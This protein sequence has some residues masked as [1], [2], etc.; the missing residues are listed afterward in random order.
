MLTF[1]ELDLIPVVP[2][3]GSV[4]ASGDLAPLSHLFL[5]LLG[6]GEFWQSKSGYGDIPVPVGQVLK[7]HS[8]STMELHAKEGLALIN[9]TQFILSHAITGR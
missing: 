1:I 9:G 6:E 5:P 3:Q 2:E 4:G 7:A 8:L